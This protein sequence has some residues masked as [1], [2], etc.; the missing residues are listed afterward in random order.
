MK[1]LTTARDEPTDGGSAGF[2]GIELWSMGTLLGEAAAEYDGH[3]CNDYDVAATPENQRIIASAIEFVYRDKTDDGTERR[4][5][6]LADGRLFIFDYW[7]MQY[8]AHRCKEVGGGNPEA[9]SD[10]ELALIADLLDD[11]AR[12]DYDLYERADGAE[13][14]ALPPTPENRDFLAD[15]IKRAAIPRWEARVAQLTSANKSV[16]AFS[17]EV[18]QWLALRCRCLVGK[19]IAAMKVAGQDFERG[20]VRGPSN[21][22]MNAVNRPGINPKWFNAWPKDRAKLVKWRS[23]NKTEVQQKLEYYVEHGVVLSNVP[24]GPGV[25]PVPLRAWERGLDLERALGMRACF[26]LIEVEMRGMSVAG[27][28]DSA[29]ALRA[30]AGI[31]TVEM[32]ELRRHC[33]Y[34]AEEAR[35]NYRHI[36]F[37]GLGIILGCTQAFEL[38]RLQVLAYRRRHYRRERAF[39]PIFHFMLRITAEFFGESPL[40][41]EGES[42]MNPIFNALLEY[43]RTKDTDDLTP[44][45]LAACDFHTIRCGP[46]PRNKFYEFGGEEFTRLP[47]EILLLFKLRQLCGLTN[48]KLDHPLINLPLGELPAE[49]AFDSIATPPDDLIYRVRQ[50]M[51]QDEY[52]ELLISEIYRRHEMA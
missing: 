48:P 26:N 5:A 39:Y 25:G 51:M 14:F 32:I 38:A 7:L 36:P 3:R 23:E 42:M 4:K 16:S 9:F 28:F 6:Q 49:I 18:L 47:I 52:N 24:W 10:S 27:S 40:D 37:T 29:E 35:M 34:T 8:F 30:F 2:S 22:S 43:W 20:G 33:R 41:V 46:T 19:S 21:G 1:R 45:C 11:L 44:L 17:T 50:R 15:V 31:Y 12:N 13:D